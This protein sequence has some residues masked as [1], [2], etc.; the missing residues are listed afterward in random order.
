MQIRS[1]IHDRLVIWIGLSLSAIFLVL[2]F[3]VITAQKEATIGKHRIFATTMIQ[4]AIIPIND[5]LYLSESD[6]RDFLQSFINNFTREYKDQIK[7]AMI[8]NQ[9]GEVMAH[10][11]VTENRNIYSD[12]YS[13]AAL[14]AIDP[15]FHIY[16]NDLYGRTIEVSAPL[17]LVSF[18]HGAIRLGL[19]AKPMISELRRTTLSIMI[20]FAGALGLIIFIVLQISR[21]VTRKLRQTVQVIDQFDFQTTDP[22]TLP[23]SDDEIG[24]LNETFLKLEERLIFARSSMEKTNK[25]M[26]QTEKLAALGRMAAGV[27]H[28]INNPLMGL[29]NCLHL[30]KIDPENS[31]DHLRLLKEGLDRIEV[32]VSSL[33]ERARKKTTADKEFDVNLCVRDVL[34]LLGPRLSTEKVIT[35]IQLD[36][37]VPQIINSKSGLEEV[38]LNICMNALDAISGIGTIKIVTKVYQQSV[39][40]TIGDSGSGISEEI[41]SKMFEPFVTTKEVGKGTGL[42]LYVTREIIDSM[43]GEISYNVSKLGGAEFQIDIPLQI[44]SE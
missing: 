1:S 24:L 4:T 12:V 14:E 8:L 37:D 42:G 33:L 43:G 13:M 29:K 20:L 17:G 27:A 35:Q 40:I 3:V 6:S 7:Y 15:A 44:D 28:E 5:A 41:Q 38:L 9:H 19:D 2:F 26:I 32:T 25:N 21:S 23:E 16:E 11:D 34:N 18:S 36:D 10:S 22:L 30:L 31:E 39:R